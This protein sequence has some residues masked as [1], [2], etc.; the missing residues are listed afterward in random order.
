MPEAPVSASVIVRDALGELM[1]RYSLGA[2][3]AST[4]QT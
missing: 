4:S 2:R 3:Y 1:M